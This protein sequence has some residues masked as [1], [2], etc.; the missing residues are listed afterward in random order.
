MIRRERG[1]IRRVTPAES[2]RH[3][4]C[5]GVYSAIVTIH[6]LS[7]GC[8]GAEFPFVGVEAV[9]CVFAEKCSEPLKDFGC[10]SR[11]VCSIGQFEAT[12]ESLVS[13]PIHKGIW[14]TI[15]LS[16]ALHM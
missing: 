5:D 3:G 16:P 14:E 4:V 2:K 10:E 15:Y 12:V 7:F 13:L 8:I 9:F 6:V 1:R 11:A